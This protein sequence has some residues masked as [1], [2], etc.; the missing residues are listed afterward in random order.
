[1]RELGYFEG[2]NL[3]I[4]ARFADGN[5]ERI[6]ALAAEVVRLT[7]TIPAPCLRSKRVA[8]L[9]QPALFLT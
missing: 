9:E 1:M 7:L 2:V 8:R 6:P 5:A 3:V 4:E